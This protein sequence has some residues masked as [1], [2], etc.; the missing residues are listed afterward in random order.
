[1]MRHASRTHVVALDWL[2]DTN[3]LDPQDPNRH[4]NQIVDLLTKGSFTRDEWCNLLRL[5][6]SIDLSMFSRSHVRSVEKATTNS[7][8]IQERK[9]EEPA[10]AKPRS[11][12]L[13]STSLN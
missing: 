11:V 4:Q 3:N 2:I 6:N 12:C 8:R 9:K 13:T 1:M 7:K 10:V 5:V